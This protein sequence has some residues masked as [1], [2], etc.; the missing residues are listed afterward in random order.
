MTAVEKMT[1]G[2]LIAISIFLFASQNVIN[3]VIKEIIQEYNKNEQ[4]IGLMGSAFM[5]VGAVLSIVIGYWSDRFSR[6]RLFS[7][8]VMLGTIP[9]FLTG[10]RFCTQSY[11]QLFI[12]RVI[13]G[14]GLAGIFPITF[15]LIGDYFSVER[16]AT[17]VG[18]VTTAWG[19]GQLLG[20]LVAG[21][22]ANSYGWRLAFILVALPNFILVPIFLKVAHEPK[23]GT[24][25]NNLASSENKPKKISEENNS[26][27]KIQ[28][29]IGWHDAKFFLGNKTNW[30]VILQGI[31]GSIPWGMLPLFL[32][33]FYE[34]Q[35]YSKEFATIIT[36]I[37]GIALT[38]G[39]IS[40][41]W[42]GDRIYHRSPAYLAIFCGISIGLGVIPTCFMMLIPQGGIW[43]NVILFFTTVIAGLLVGLP[44]GNGKAI[45]L[46]TNAPQHRGSV[47]S[48][49]NIG[50]SLGRGI[51][52]M[53]G[54]IWITSYGYQ[55]AMIYSI[56]LWIPCSILFGI[57]AAT[58]KNDLTRLH[59]YLQQESFSQK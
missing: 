25:E 36:M 44:S 21:F 51:G 14:I 42:L 7:W 45:L 5:I 37:L 16:R 46:N 30:L 1:L 19:I 53:L 4:D 2:L 50:D 33:A 52:P 10:L 8:V 48:L 29:E 20:Q 3:P 27:V 9:C 26:T 47:F 54:G 18:L 49:N 59:N 31:P 32:T 28:K 12:L 13:T 17:V 11:E 6:V 34:G 15:S 38:F 23:R 40:G 57:V 35:G 41:G 58:I 56:L 55:D 43:S 39:G 22:I 24:K